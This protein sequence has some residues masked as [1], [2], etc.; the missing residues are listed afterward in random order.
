MRPDLGFQFAAAEDFARPRHQGQQQ[1]EGAAAEP[2]FLVL[3][4]QA[5]GV[6]VQ[7]ER[8]EGE[9]RRRLCGSHAGHLV[10][11]DSDVARDGVV[12]GH[13]HAARKQ[14]FTFMDGG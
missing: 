14:S 4:A 11:D 5:Q 10:R 3:A 12:D 6:G 7:A 2:H 8:T 1:I 9:R 13:G